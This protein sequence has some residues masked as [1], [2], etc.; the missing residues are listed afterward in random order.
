MA[1]R[2]PGSYSNYP[3]PF[4]L[5]SEFQPGYQLHQGIKHRLPL[6]RVQGLIDEASRDAIIGGETPLTRSIKSCRR[7]IAQELIAKG[8]DVNATSSQGEF[9]LQVCFEHGEIELAAFLVR[10]GA[11]LDRIPVPEQNSQGKSQ[12]MP[13]LELITKLRDVP[14]AQKDQDFVR[15]ENSDEMGWLHWAAQIGHKG[16]AQFLIDYGVDNKKGDSKGRAPIHFAAKEGNV[17]VLELFLSRESSLINLCDSHGKTPL[18]HA[19][20]NKKIEAIKVLLSKGANPQIQDKDR[21]SAAHYAVIYP[22]DSSLPLYSDSFK[23]E[24][25]QACEVLS[26]LVEKCPDLIKEVDGKSSPSILGDAIYSQY[27]VTAKFLIEHGADLT[28]P[29]KSGDLLIHMALLIDRSGELLELMCERF[30][31]CMESRDYLLNTPLL[32]A[33]IIENVWAMVYLINRGADVTVKNAKG[34]NFFHYATSVY[35]DFVFSD[36]ELENLFAEINTTSVSRE[37]IPGNFCENL[38]NFFE[39]ILAKHPQLLHEKNNEGITPLAEYFHN[40]Y[41][42]SETAMPSF[43]EYWLEK[44]PSYSVT[45]KEGFSVLHVAARYGA[46][47]DI[48]DKILAVKPDLINQSA[49][50]QLTPLGSALQ[51]DEIRAA[52]YLLE[53]GAN[54]FTTYG[55][56]KQWTD[57]QKSSEAVKRFFGFYEGQVKKT[58]ASGSSLSDPEQLLKVLQ[59]LNHCWKTFQEFHLTFENQ[60]QAKIKDLPLATAFLASIPTLYPVLFSDD[61]AL[62]PRLKAYLDHLFNQ[63]E[64]ENRDDII[65]RI[66]LQ[67]SALQAVSRLCAAYF[68]T[69]L[70]SQRDNPY[71]TLL[72]SCETLCQRHQSL[73][74]R[75]EAG[76]EEKMRSAFAKAEIFSLLGENYGLAP[77]DMDGVKSKDLYASHLYCQEEDLYKVGL[78]EG[79]DL[80]RLGIDSALRDLCNLIE[81]ERV[82]EQRQEHC[83][84]LKEILKEKRVL[85]T[86]LQEIFPRLVAEKLDHLKGL[87]N[88]SFEEK[89]TFSKIKEFDRDLTLDL[90][91]HFLA[92]RDM[93][94]LSLK[95]RLSAVT[96]GIAQI[97]KVLKSAELACLSDVDDKLLP[98]CFYQLS[99]YIINK[100]EL[101]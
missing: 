78:C 28:V 80:N 24:D 38:K 44:D 48:L 5:V 97:E 27:R 6:Q 99:I 33:A 4:S 26:L 45:T 21:K 52:Y 93:S 101:S 61:Y 65:L 94:Q 1:S 57:F 39:E 72:D 100:K 86:S 76:G 7:D 64:S 23:K 71:S 58:V 19:T 67:T 88:E 49:A 43:F 89:Q 34:D 85:L 91:S 79:Q 40:A 42:N 29:D 8:A 68:K 59:V 74:A 69:G 73:K 82:P 63:Y 83:V 11:K 22:K 2:V 95:E 98:A 12:A 75:V 15:L 20:E 30:P 32:N 41:Y 25:K 36:E 84:R 60:P 35:M 53:K 56:G 87:E 3:N 47:S 9:P 66:Q 31:D 37:F 13:F 54:L 90:L 16:A 96:K 92:Q 10:E 50:N 17:D 51:H 70:G 77:S 81:G 55:W 14:S 62:A 18:I 46:K